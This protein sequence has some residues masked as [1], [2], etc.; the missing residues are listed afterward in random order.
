MSLMI[1]EII[2]EIDKD[3]DK[4]EEFTPIL[5]CIRRFTNATINSKEPD[6]KDV[7]RSLKRKKNK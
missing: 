7:F 6:W 5:N 3:K 2:T 1:K 4:V